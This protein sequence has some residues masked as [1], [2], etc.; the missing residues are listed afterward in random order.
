MLFFEF[1]APADE[2]AATSSD[3]L[4]D[5]DSPAVETA[6]R[7]GDK[8]PMVRTMPS[9]GKCWQRVGEKR[10]KLEVLSLGNCAGVTTWVNRP[11]S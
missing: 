8:V 9:L 3:A 2:F 6:T 10:Q 4:T 7:G 11:A 5:T 1:L